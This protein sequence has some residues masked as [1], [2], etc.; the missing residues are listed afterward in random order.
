MGVCR[1]IQA[2]L[3]RL[4]YIKEY[5]YTFVQNVVHLYRWALHSLNYGLVEK[6]VCRVLIM[7]MCGRGD[8][9]G[10]FVWSF[11]G[12]YYRYTYGTSL[13]AILQVY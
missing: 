1:H 12:Q 6:G 5:I 7:G 11:C 13:Q 10:K 2:I 8:T 9:T 4:F 3:C